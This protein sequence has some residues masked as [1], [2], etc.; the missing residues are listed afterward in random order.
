[1]GKISP[2]SQA[3]VLKLVERGHDAKEIFEKFGQNNWRRGGIKSLVRKIKK[4][5][6]IER[7]KGKQ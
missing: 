4:T 6:G 2:K 7:I 5:G 1:M 3:F